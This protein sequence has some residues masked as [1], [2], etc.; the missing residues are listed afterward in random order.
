MNPMQEL[1]FFPVNNNNNNN[2]VRNN[3]TVE[4]SHWQAQTQGLLTLWGVH[5]LDSETKEKVSHYG[6]EL[7]IKLLQ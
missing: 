7:Y 1:L 6:I 5:F 3:K 4:T 2:S